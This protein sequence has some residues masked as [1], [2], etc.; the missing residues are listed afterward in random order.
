MK[1]LFTGPYKDGTGYSHGAIEYILSLLETDADVVCRSVQMT[2]TS[3]HVPKEILELEKK[4]INNI[5]KI[6]QYNLPTTF[7]RSGK[8]ENIGGFAYETLG[9]PMNSWIEGI[10]KMD[11]VISPCEFQ[12]NNIKNFCPNT[13]VFTVPHSVDTSDEYRNKE[14]PEINL[15][16]DSNTLVFY[17][18]SEESPRKNLHSLIMSYFM[19]FSSSDNVALVI[20]T[21]IPGIKGG[22]A[23]KHIQDTINNVKMSCKKYANDELFPRVTVTTDYVSESKIRAIHN[24]GDVFVSASHGEGWCLPFVDALNHGNAAIVPN[25][26]AFLDHKEHLQDFGVDYVD[27]MITPCFGAANSLELY[28]ANESW[29]SISIGD[30][31]AKMINIYRQKRDYYLDKETVKIR[32]DYVSSKLNRKTVGKQLI[33]ALGA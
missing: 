27:G 19:A 29:F 21:H 22:E 20:K 2:N 7:V 11:K 14:I 10:L 28:T 17:T 31:A 18:I 13:E 33:Q 30:M 5:D 6:F 26:G 16:I 12:S 25:F 8:A 4:D 9:M 3:G 23:K 24:F 15:P 32:K 1:V